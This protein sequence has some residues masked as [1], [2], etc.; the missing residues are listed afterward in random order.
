[1]S[2]EP[3]RSTAEKT[4]Q[5]RLPLKQVYN[6]LNNNMRIIDTIN[7]DRILDE[8]KYVRL[9][10]KCHYQNYKLILYS[11]IKEW[12]LGGS[13]ST[14]QHQFFA[15]AGA[16]I[17]IFNTLNSK[18]ISMVFRATNAKEFLNHS[19]FY[20]LYGFDLIDPNFQYG[21]PIVLTE[22][23]Y[24]ADVLR[25]IYPN[26]MATLTSSITMMMA[27]TLSLMTDHI[28]VAFDADDAGISGF[29]KVYKRMTRLNPNCVIKKLPVFPGDKDVGT[30]EEKIGNQQEY[31]IRWKYYQEKLTEIMSDDSDAIYL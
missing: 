22:G 21:Q 3:Y 12:G 9:A 29:D 1:M 27:E 30:M 6:I 15:D 13:F 26:V 31:S 4:G 10:R 24:D 23:I 11:N 25:Q 19:L 16:A 14:Y 28:I 7:P 5:P 8:S 17:G 20:N 18:V 2:Y